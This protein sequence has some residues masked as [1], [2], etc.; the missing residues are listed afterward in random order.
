MP[1]HDNTDIHNWRTIDKEY[2]KINGKL[3][4]KKSH[5]PEMLKVSDSTLK[6]K[7]EKIMLKDS[8][9]IDKKDRLNILKECK[10]CKEDKIVISHGT[11]TIAETAKILG[12]N[13]KD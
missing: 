9:N 3:I 2:D 11:D 6:F 5:I 12:K 10:A 4:L 1:S 13:I 8:L 7:L